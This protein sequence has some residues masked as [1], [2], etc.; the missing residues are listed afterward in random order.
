MKKNVKKVFTIAAVI[1]CCILMAAVPVSAAKKPS[2]RTVAKVYSRH[3]QKYVW[4]AKRYISQGQTTDTLVD[5]NKDGIPELVVQYPYGNKMGVV[6]YTYKKGK[7]VRMT[8]KRGYIGISSVYQQKGKSKK[9]LVLRW[10]QDRQHSGYDVYQMKGTKLK[11]VYRYT[12]QYESLSEFNQG[13]YAYIPR[14]NGKYIGYGNYDKFERSLRDCRYQ[15]YGDWV[16]F[17]Y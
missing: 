12:Y 13:G 3:L 11:R 16:D 7:I 2:M 8:S 1:M 9:Y 14:R 5:I 17:C 15:D 4:R 10:T 6:V